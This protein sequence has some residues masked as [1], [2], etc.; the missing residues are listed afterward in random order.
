MGR[1]CTENLCNLHEQSLPS[2]SPSSLLIVGKLIKVLRAHLDG[3][4][5]LAKVR[6]EDNGQRKVVDRLVGDTVTDGRPGEMLQTEDKGP[7][8]GL[9][10]HG[11]KEH[12]MGWVLVVLNESGD[13]GRGVDARVVRVKA[14]A[15][16]PL[17][18]AGVQ[19]A[20]KATEADAKEVVLLGRVAQE[21]G[22][23]GLALE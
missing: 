18:N 5:V 10:Q 4:V 13:G 2:P 9:R 21:E 8:K 22:A 20:V 23:L 11:L 12:T 17:L 7:M 19:R 1:S 14:E 3:K 16:L 15:V 6:L